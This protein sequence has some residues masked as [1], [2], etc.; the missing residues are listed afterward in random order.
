MTKSPIIDS[1]MSVLAQR[2][3][4]VHEEL[5]QIFAQLKHTESEKAATR[6][7]HKLI[8]ANL[9]LVMSIAKKYVKSNTIPFEDLIQE[10][11]IGLMKAVDK[12]DHTRGFKF[13]TYATWWIRQAI[14]QYLQNKR[15]IVRL[16]AH[17]VKLQRDMM[18]ATEEFK[19][20]HG[21]DPTESELKDITGASKTVMKATFF[22]GRGVVS[23]D[24]YA[25]SQAA[26]GGEPRT[27]KNVI[28]D[29]NPNVDP[30]K[31]VDEARSI[32]LIRKVMN[33]ELSQ[34]EVAIIRLRFGLV[35]DPTD[36]DAYPVTEEEISLI[37]SGVGLSNVS[38]TGDQ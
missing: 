24:D 26:G 30:F 21:F 18:N 36:S 9:R 3:Q 11:N 15:R 32:S 25:S 4:I 29:E 1:Y 5:M 28:P 33:E 12:F 22:S 6:L 13:S 34:K 16:P 7:K 10:G 2:P 14:C 35:E 31:N 37:Q 8:E 38:E 23:L 17:A 20:E 19:K 27:W